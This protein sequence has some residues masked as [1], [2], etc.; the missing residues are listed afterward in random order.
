MKAMDANNGGVEAKQFSLGGYIEQ[1][2]QIRINL[3]IQTTGGHSLSCSW[4]AELHLTGAIVTRRFLVGALA[5]GTEGMSNILAASASVAMPATFLPVFI[6]TFL[7]DFLEQ[8]LDKTSAWLSFCS[9]R[10]PDG[11]SV[12]MVICCSAGGLAV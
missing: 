10:P 9:N 6:L 12:A 7:A 2:S 3:T 11:S 4:A 5:L 1:W 8:R